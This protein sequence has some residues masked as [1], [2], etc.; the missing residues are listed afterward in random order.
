M[1]KVIKQINTRLY[2]IGKEF[3]KGED[4]LY[5]EL[6]KDLSKIPNLELT[7]SGVSM[8]TKDEMAIQSALASVGT[9]GEYKDEV[10]PD[11]ELSKEQLKAEINAKA[12]LE[13][14]FNEI[15]ERFYEE[16]NLLKTSLDYSKKYES[17][18]LEIDSLLH[19]KGEQFTWTLIADIV[20]K[21]KKVGD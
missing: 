9:I 2:R 3:G 13:D 14:D 19:H 6:M 1:N 18:V 4:T 20:D 10:D 17:R 15:L 11:S 21:M 16:A 5:S 8:S 12:S 7:K